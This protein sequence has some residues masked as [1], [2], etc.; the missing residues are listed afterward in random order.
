MTILK[1]GSIFFFQFYI[2]LLYHV[3]NM[4]QLWALPYN[5]LEEHFWFTSY[6]K[7]AHISSKPLLIYIYSYSFRSMQCTLVT[8]PSILPLY[9]EWH[10]V[11]IHYF[12]LTNLPIIVNIRIFCLNLQLLGKHPYTAN[13]NKNTHIIVL[14]AR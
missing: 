5:V 8:F 2:F 12:K 6:S 10:W 9:N 3:I 13:V 4:T 14:W 7:N 1:R 11:W